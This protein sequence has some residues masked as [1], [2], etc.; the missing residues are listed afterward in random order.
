MK[1]KNKD[2]K[3]K[4]ITVNLNDPKSFPKWNVNQ[5]ILDSTTEEDIARQIIE[6]E[7]EAKNDAETYKKSRS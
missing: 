2:V 7:L 5:K 3:I 4:R 6:D 1:E